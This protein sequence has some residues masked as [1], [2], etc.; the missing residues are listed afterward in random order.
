MHT[1]ANPLD[2]QATTDLTPVNTSHPQNGRPAKRAARDRISA[3]SQPKRNAESMAPLP[4]NF[5]IHNTSSSTN[6][7]K[8]SQQL[9]YTL[10]LF[11]DDSEDLTTPLTQ[12]LPPS[13][14]SGTRYLSQDT[15]LPTTI[16]AL[17]PK[18]SRGQERANLVWHCKRNKAQA[19][20]PITAITSIYKHELNYKLIDRHKLFKP[21]RRVGSNI[22]PQTYQKQY[23]THWA[24][25]TIE[26]WAIAIF[27]AAGFKKASATATKRSDIHCACCEIAL[28]GKE[29]SP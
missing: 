21:H 11:S 1:Q 28:I 23:H 22:S 24:P 7:T 26:E 3:F 20:Q 27:T 15:N 9:P 29:W 2:S 18:S 25:M 16:P 4:P 17:L 6:S 5:Q 14:R 12:P 8:M 19:T 13:K 10:I